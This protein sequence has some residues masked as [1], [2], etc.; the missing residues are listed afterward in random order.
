MASSREKRTKG[1]DLATE[2]DTVPSLV[3]PLL[4]GE[5]E[6]EEKIEKF[7]GEEGKRRRPHDKNFSLNKIHWVLK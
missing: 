3:P 6:K 5:G 1:M 2:V 7:A 4:H